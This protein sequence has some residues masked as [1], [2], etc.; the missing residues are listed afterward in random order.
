MILEDAML[1]QE[2]SS[3]VYFA[4]YSPELNEIVTD[5]SNGFISDEKSGTALEAIINSISANGYQIVINPGT[6][7]PKQDMTL[8]TLHGKLGGIGSDGKIPTIAVIAHYDSF[9]VAPVCKIYGFFLI[10]CGNFQ[11]D[12]LETYIFKI[13][14]LFCIKRHF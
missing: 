9:G 8:V 2:I 11:K 4:K 3:P 12:F 13:R 6:A 14:V 1:A 7:G 10:K 5:I